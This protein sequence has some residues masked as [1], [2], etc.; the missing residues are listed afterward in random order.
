MA[1]VIGAGLVIL[2]AERGLTIRSIRV[3][4]CHIDHDGLQTFKYRSYFHASDHRGRSDIFT[5][6]FLSHSKHAINQ[7]SVLALSALNPLLRLSLT[8][9]LPPFRL[10]EQSADCY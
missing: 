9:P 7:S 4:L 2:F 8:H 6:I 3:L 1:L 5:C 10:I